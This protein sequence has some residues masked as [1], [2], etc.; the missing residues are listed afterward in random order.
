MVAKIVTMTKANTV[1]PYP[2][3]FLFGGFSKFGVMPGGGRS[4]GVFS[5]SSEFCIL[6]EARGDLDE[7]CVEIESGLTGVEVSVK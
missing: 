6:G 3:A 1:R 2:R 4:A 7:F 5:N